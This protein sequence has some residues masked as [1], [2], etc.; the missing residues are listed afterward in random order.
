MWLDNP[1]ESDQTDLKNL[2]GSLQQA[3]KDNP[4]AKK[5]IG[6]LI[7]KVKSTENALKAI[8]ELSWVKVHGGDIAIGH[9]PGAKLISDLRLYRTTHVFTLLSEKEGGKKT[10][11]MAQKSGIEWLWFPM[12][13]AK[14][15]KEERLQHLA[16]LF[17]KIKSIL[18]D[19]GKVYIHCSA[20]IH[21]T[22]MI[23]YALLRYL[24]YSEKESLDLLSQLR[25]TT[26]EGVGEERVE[27]AESVADK[28]IE[29]SGK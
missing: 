20:G 8:Q 4:D 19:N 24:A 18:S 7:G 16:E 26:S 9:R 23:S 27:W 10:E 25:D 11:S 2:I 5:S 6:P 12:E 28:L 3:M 17:A 15:P 21:R 1:L 13:S 29:L 14:P 22:G